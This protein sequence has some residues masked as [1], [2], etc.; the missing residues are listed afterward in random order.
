MSEAGTSRNPQEAAKA[1][2]KAAKASKRREV[3]AGTQVGVGERADREG[4]RAALQ[5]ALQRD[6]QAPS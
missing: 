6:H 3:N 2:A 1:E 4:L 5:E